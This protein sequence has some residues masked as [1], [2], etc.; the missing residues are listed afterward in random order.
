MG[1]RSNSGATCHDG[2]RVSLRYSNPLGG[3]P[4]HQGMNQLRNVLVVALA[5]SLQDACCA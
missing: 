1:E 3:V 4:F 5:A 2:R